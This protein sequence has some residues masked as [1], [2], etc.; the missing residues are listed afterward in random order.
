MSIGKPQDITKGIRI[1]IV[2]ERRK[3]APAMRVDNGKKVKG[4]SCR[5]RKFHIPILHKKGLRAQSNLGNLWLCDT[6]VILKLHEDGAV[7]TPGV[8]HDLLVLPDQR[9]SQYLKPLVER[10]GRDRSDYA[11]R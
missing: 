9:V 2:G 6:E 10:K 8:E 1:F 3:L 5:Y 4:R 7:K 11:A